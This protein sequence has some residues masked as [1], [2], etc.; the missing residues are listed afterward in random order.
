MSN[1]GSYQFRNTWYEYAPE[2]LTTGNAEKY[3]YVLQYCTDLLL[4]K[5]NQAIEIRL[6]GQGDASQLPYL[7]NDRVLVQGPAEPTANFVIRLQESLQTW[8]LAGSARSVL[9]NLQAYVQGLQPGVPVTNPLLTIIGGSSTY[10]KWTQLYQ[11]D[12]IG[13]L[14]TI[15]TKTPANFSWDGLN[16]PWRSWLVLPMALVT[17]SSG[18]GAATTTA[19]GGSYTSPGQNVSGVWIPATSGTVVNSPWITIT[20]LAGVAAGSWLTLSGSSHAANNGTFPVVQ[21][22]SSTSAVIAN[23]GGVTSDTGLA[24]SIGAYP[25]I[26]PG[27][28]RGA[29]GVVYGQ[30]ETSAPAVDTGRVFGG[31]WQP[32]GA[33]AQGLG[34]L[35]SWGLNVS[36]QVIQSIRGIVRTWKSA[37]T[38][39]PNIVVAFDSGTG[40]AGSPYSPNSTEGS[41]NPA[42]TFG[43]VGSNVSGVWSPTRLITSTY[44]AFCQG[45][46][47]Y[48]ACSVENVN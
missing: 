44:D 31:V 7:A 30:G 35:I 26:G 4:E 24:W 41:G 12:A 48:Q 11:G 5:M 9:L 29:P 6:P 14:P 17:T 22:I 13:A 45:T 1:T 46:G 25:W 36:S 32:S 47:S 2:W 43:Q 21:A 18:T 3:L 28:A 8:G 38:Y 40:V 33:T 16:R 15:T 23:P 42:G 10:T 39:Y 37:S 27:P 20:G 19:T 34:P